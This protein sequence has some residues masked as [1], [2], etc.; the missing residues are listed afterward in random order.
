MALPLT[1]RIAT[2]TLNVRAQPSASAAKIGEVHLN[3]TV[4]VVGVDRANGWFAIRWQ[5]GTAWISGQYTD[6]APPTAQL[7]LPAAVKITSDSLNARNLPD[8]ASASQG[9]LA[10]NAAL[11]VLG[12]SGDGVWLAVE[13]A[14]A[15]AWLM[16]RFIAPAD[17]AEVG[18]YPARNVRGVH[19]SP[20]VFPPPREDW[21]YWLREMRELK[22]GWIK[23][24]EQGDGPMLE[25]ALACKASGIEPIMRVWAGR[26]L[27]DRLEDRHFNKMREYAGH[28]IRWYELY[29]EPNLPGLE[30]K[31]EYDD[32]TFR[33]DKPGICDVLMDH[34]LADA[35]RA[36]E[37]G[38]WPAFPAIGATDWGS[39]RG[40]GFSFSSVNF[41]RRCIEIIAQDPARRS[42]FLNLV[43]NG[44]WVAVH[45]SP[46]PASQA[47]DY[48]PWNPED[49]DRSRPWDICLRGYEI[50]LR[51]LAELL[52]VQNTPVISTE[53]GMFSAK[54]RA[55][56]GDAIYAGFVRDGQSDH[57][58]IAEQW[59][60]D[61]IRMYN[62]IEKKTPLRALCSWIFNDVGVGDPNWLDSGWY[63]G[64]EPMPIIPMLKR[65]WAAS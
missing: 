46:R 49:G 30:W 24:L 42:R 10:K 2:R 15:T 21:D 36:A 62:F 59:G 63:R 28:G 47:L 48:D 9:V 52:G 40:P 34:W 32:G 29:N 57:N 12:I 37:A 53:G 6:P 60:P 27:P 8:D 58:R 17:P 38:V 16:R 39:G 13:R 20:V 64:K 18:A 26:H 45:V 33:W 5:G 11:L 44:A 54:E 7:D 51:Y 14:G 23:L 50:P 35:E 65:A 3:D 61:I 4:Q 56:I 25:W 43:K 55:R 1:V 22:V 41:T 31:P 19:W